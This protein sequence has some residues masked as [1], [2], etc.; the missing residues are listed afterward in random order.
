METQAKKVLRYPHAKHMDVKVNRYMPAKPKPKELSRPPRPEIGSI[1][2][3]VDE[4]TFSSG[5]ANL[6]DMYKE[7]SAKVVGDAVFGHGSKHERLLQLQ[8]EETSKRWYVKE[9]EIN[10]PRIMDR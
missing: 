6:D 1:V 4:K 9:S 5:C 10:L 2:W 3:F 7:P 8:S